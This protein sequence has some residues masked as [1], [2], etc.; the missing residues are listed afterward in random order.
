[1]HPLRFLLAESGLGYLAF[2]MLSL[3]VLCEL[4][5]WMVVR[6]R[7]LGERDAVVLPGSGVRRWGGSL[8]G[9]WHGSGG[10][11]GRM[12]IWG[13]RRTRT[14]LFGESCGGK[15]VVVVV[16]NVVKGFVLLL[17]KYGTYGSKG[18]TFSRNE[19]KPLCVIVV[20]VAC[21]IERVLYGSG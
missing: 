20:A 18:E 1:M 17:V 21:L 9:W 5:R 11:G 6:N 4:G 13:C 16:V 3:M 19:V 8:Q 10:R 12:A 7:F 2:G 14:T 15:V